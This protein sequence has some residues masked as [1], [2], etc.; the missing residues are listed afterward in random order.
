M[1]NILTKTFSEHT[2]DGEYIQGLF[3]KPQEGG[4]NVLSEYRLIPDVTNAKTLFIPG[5]LTK[6]LKSASGC[7]FTEGGQLAITDRKLTVCDMKIEFGQCFSD[8]VSEY[9]EMFLNQGSTIGD[10]QGTFIQDVVEQKGEDAFN[11]DVPRV[12]WF[13]DADDANA[14]WTQCDGWISHMVD[15]SAKLGQFLNMDSTAGETG[16]ALA[17]DGAALILKNMWENRS[18]TLRRA[19]NQRIYVTATVVDNLLD[20]YEDTQSS[21]GLLRLIDGETRQLTYRGI[22]VIEVEGWDTHLADTDNPHY[23]GSGLGI[24]SN[25]IVW[26]T[27]DTLLIGTNL[28]DPGNDMDVWYEKKDEKVYW[29][30]RFKLGTQIL[31]PELVSLAY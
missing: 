14:D 5:N 1:A 15:T 10:V 22:P 24:G 7:G 26:T 28:A 19:P 23:T 21:A 18:K 2:Y 8:F 3:Y 12:A 30:I 31:H 16:D 27:P 17:T 25:L 13:A 9:H 20:T 11:S 29:R 4:Q 6:V